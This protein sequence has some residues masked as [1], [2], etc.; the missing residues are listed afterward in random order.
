MSDHTCVLSIE[1]QCREC[2]RE[3]VEH[4]R[5]LER[6]A[7]VE[8]LRAIP[9]FDVDTQQLLDELILFIE[10]GEHLRGNNE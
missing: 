2:V 8:W 4:G 10:S 6:A 5:V 9:K 3:D 7:I 1:S